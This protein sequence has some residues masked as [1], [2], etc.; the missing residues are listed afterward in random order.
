MNI[1][2]YAIEKKVIMYICVIIL[3]VGGIWGF[4]NVGRL[5]DPDFII[6]EV[7]INTAYPGATAFE[8]EQEVGDLIESQVQKL[9]DLWWVDAESQAGLSIITARF[10]EGISAEEYR[11]IY[12]ELRR[13]VNDVQGQLP[14]GAGP[15]IVNDDFKD[16]FGIMLAVTGDGFSEKEIYDHAELLLKQLAPLP[17]VSKIEFWGQPTETIYIDI[18]RATIVTLGLSEDYLYSLIKDQNIVSPRGISLS[19]GTGSDS[20]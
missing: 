19:S 13:K 14:P 3:F 7:R 9:P 5:E 12:D 1:A 11:Q 4:N 18:P 17:G 8:V 2:E 20:S 16:V 10:H 15:S 6:N